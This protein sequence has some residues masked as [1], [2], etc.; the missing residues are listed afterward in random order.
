MIVRHADPTRDALGCVAV[1]APAVEE[2]VASFEEIVPDVAMMEHRIATIARRHP[3]IVA[4]IDGVI[5][6]FSYA[7]PHR[8]RAAY[9]WAVDVSIY[10]GADFHRRG[11][12]RALYEA[13][14][15]L[16][17][18][19]GLFHAFAGITLP[20]DGSIGLHEALGFTPVGVFHGVGFKH[21]AWHDVGWWQL[22]LQPLPP[23]GPPPEPLGPQRLEAVDGA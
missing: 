13:L 8:E 11:V 9:R 15:G 14:I 7:A 17:R 23:D 6:G 12:G 5:A 16:L 1:Y 18:R 2:S 4:E 19:Q 22:E 21:G 3:W 20:N 10:I